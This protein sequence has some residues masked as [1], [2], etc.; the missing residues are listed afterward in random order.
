[1]KY[2]TFITLVIGAGVLVGGGL[3]YLI[4]GAVERSRAEQ[5]E[6]A[7]EQL[8]QQRDLGRSTDALDR[9]AS[10][11]V[12]AVEPQMRGILG[13]PSSGETKRKDLFEGRGPKIN[14][15]AE[16]GVWARAKVDIDRDDKWDE[17]WR[18]DSGTIYRAVSANDDEDY[19]VEIALAEVSTPTEPAPVPAPTGDTSSLREVDNLMLELLGRP[20][21]AKI[22]DASAGRPFK[23]NLY[24][25]DGVR[26]NRAKV[27]LDR[28]DKWDEKWEFGEDSITRK[29][30]SADDDATYDQRFEL[31]ASGR[32]RAVS[33]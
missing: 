9:A 19:G 32:W 2:K 6:H 10:Q 28:D 1:M 15:Y 14:I 18:W 7:Q 5:R 31:E 24:S 16:D 30:S 23:I 4:A 17:K 3:I 20:V 27:D 33:E 12:F 22:K 25:D 21:V 8:E 26:F 11:G 13:T 29:V